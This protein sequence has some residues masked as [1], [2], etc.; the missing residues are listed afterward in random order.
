MIKQSN[1]VTLYIRKQR[2]MLV[3][4]IPLSVRMIYP[5]WSR[6]AKSWAFFSLP[7]SPTSLAILSCHGD[8]HWVGVLTIVPWQ[9]VKVWYLETNAFSKRR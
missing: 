5:G 3:S 7:I 9:A 6:K 8:E 4:E 1:T 2:S